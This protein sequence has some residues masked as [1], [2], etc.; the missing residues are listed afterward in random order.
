MGLR[1]LYRVFRE[2]R[3]AARQEATLAVTGDSP[4]AAE[5]AAR[6]G[7][8]RVIKGAEVILTLS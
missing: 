7:A 3:D 5:I 2:T 6:L 4:R 8:Q 1:N